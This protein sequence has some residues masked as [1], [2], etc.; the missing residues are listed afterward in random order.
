MSEARFPFPDRPRLWGVAVS[1]YQVEGNDPCDWTDWETQGK[2]RGESCGTAVNSW[3]L[4]EHDAELAARLGANAFRFSISWSRVEPEPGSFDETALARYRR[5]VEKLVELDMEPIVTLF[6]YTHPRWFHEKTPWTSPRSVE[7]FTRFAR[8]TAEALGPHARLYTI[9]NEPLI[10]ILGG[11]LD[12]QIPPG[13]SDARQAGRALDHMLA[14]HAASAAVIREVNPQAA[15]GVA[16]NMMGFAPDRPRNFLDRLL[17]RR[18]YRFYNLQLLEAFTTGRWSVLVPPATRLSGRRDDL[19]GS[20][21][22]IGV[23][24]YSRLHLRCPGKKRFIGDFAYVDRTGRGLT[25]NGWEIAPDLFGPLLHEAAKFGLPLLVTENGIA[26]ANDSLRER[27]LREH[28]AEIVQAEKDGVPIAGYLH[29]SLLDNYEW[30]DG[31]GPKFGLC[32][33]DRETQKRTPRSSA[34]VFKSLGEE[35]L[36]A[37]AGTGN[38][39]TRTLPRRP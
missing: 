30:L 10:F 7:A 33:V 36:D 12:G 22:V 14:A 16:H 35:W 9:L 28:V 31:Y 3:D 18:A 5:L 8:K 1:H 6:H 13:I 21:D 19:V 34:A 11:F 2:T 26:D 39:P 15:I 25:D 4:Y 17:A 32:S 38:R 37:R 23:N 24:Y 29:W 27:F 20:L